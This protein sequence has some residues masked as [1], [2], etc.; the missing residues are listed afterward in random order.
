MVKLSGM[1]LGFVAVGGLALSLATGIG[2]AS[3]EPDLAPLVNT[4]CSYSQAI[5]ALNANSPDA[6]QAFNGSVLAQFWLR[7]FLGSSPDQRQHMLQGLSASRA[8]QYLGPALQAAGTC[9]NY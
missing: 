7:S 1:K 9:N 2:V 8:Q 3:A 5:A 4:T 6:A